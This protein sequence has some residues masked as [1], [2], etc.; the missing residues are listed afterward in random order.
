MLNIQVVFFDK[1]DQLEGKQD[2][3]IKLGFCKTLQP[4]L[5]DIPVEC[6]IIIGRNFLE[7][8]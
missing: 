1:V 7:N 8:I 2:L 5:Q 6:P 3:S 4:Y